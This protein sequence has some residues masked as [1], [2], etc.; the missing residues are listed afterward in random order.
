V[1]TYPPGVPLLMAAATLIG[2]AGAPFLVVPLLGGLAV[3]LTYRLGR[4]VL[5]P[6]GA[7]VA[8]MLV[9]TSPSFLREL[10]VPTSDVAATALWTAAVLLV[11]GGRRRALVGA[12]LAASAAIAVRPNLIL[13]TAAL[14]LAILAARPVGGRRAVVGNLLAFVAGLVPGGMIVAGVNWYL[15]GSP[16]RSGYGDVGQLY[17]FGYALT[18]ARRYTSWLW[19]THTPLLLL[20]PFALARPGALAGRAEGASGA[21]PAISPATVF[22]AVMVAVPLSYLFYLTFSSWTYLRF[23]LP[24]FPVLAVAGVAGLT[25]VCSRVPHHWRATFVP[26]VA[27]AAVTVQARVAIDQGLLTLRSDE[28]RYVAIA[29][30]A[31]RLTPANAMLLS[32]QHSGTL[33]YYAHR[34]T[35]RYDHVVPGA[36]GSTIASLQAHGYRPYVVLDDWEV[37]EFRARFGPEALGPA[38][39]KPLA[40]VPGGTGLYDP[41]PEHD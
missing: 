21:R 37:P 11:L 6:P 4:R 19:E 3:F 26:L 15:Y 17:A 32:M 31:E 24:A 34:L 1:P 30:A 13:V 36:L 16:F 25:D 8:A 29:A 12:G 9:G 35:L 14:G 33:R 22:Y 20:V 18:N 10:M 7:L 40:T 2:G 41:L 27:I 23:L 38:G 28:Q 5:D 39:R